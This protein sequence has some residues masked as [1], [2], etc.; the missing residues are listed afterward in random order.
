LVFVQARSKSWGWQVLN[1]QIILDFPEQKDVYVL[2]YAALIRED[3]QAYVQ[4][5]R[6]SPLPFV[7]I[8]LSVPEKVEPK[9]DEPAR[10]GLLPEI[11]RASPDLGRFSLPPSTHHPLK[12]GDA[13]ESESVCH[14]IEFSFGEI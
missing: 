9:L 8:G 6:N 3:I 13:V 1:Q 2:H 4:D 10:I 12:L 5:R 7:K 11:R 14:I